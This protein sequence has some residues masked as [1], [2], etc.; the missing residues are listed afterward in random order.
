MPVDNLDMN[1][2]TITKTG[3]ITV[4]PEQAEE[5]VN[6]NIEYAVT[7]GPY[8]QIAKS[9]ALYSIPEAMEIN[10]NTGDLLMTKIQVEFQLNSGSSEAIDITAPSLNKDTI[11]RVNMSDILTDKNDLINY[12]IK[13]SRIR[14]YLSLIHI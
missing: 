11:I 5:G 10:M 8:V 7:R 1:T 2:W 6:L 12:P 9:I 4:T 3:A 13:L 14:F